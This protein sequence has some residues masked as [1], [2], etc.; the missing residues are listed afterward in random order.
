MTAITT[1][2]EQVVLCDRCD[3][4]MCRVYGVLEHIATGATGCAEFIAI[5]DI[6][7]RNCGS[8]WPDD[9]GDDPYGYT[10]CCSDLVIRPGQCKPADGP[11]DFLHCVH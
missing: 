10:T 5:D 3:Q 2:H 4:P 11:A 8:T 9:I 1:E 7:C 6:H